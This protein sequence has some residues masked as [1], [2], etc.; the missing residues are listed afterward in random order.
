GLSNNKTTP[1]ALKVKTSKAV[2]DLYEDMEVMS[3]VE[4]EARYEIELEAYTKKIQIESR[5][6][7]DIS[8]NHVVP[9]AIIYQ[10]TLLENTKNLKEIF[11]ENF[12][13]IAKEQI[14]LIMVIS[15]HIT[16]I[17]A[18]VNKMTQERKNANRH[19]GLKS[20]ELYCN[21]VKPFFEEIRYHCDKLETMVDDNL[22]PLTK[23]RELLFTR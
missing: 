8:R 14:E 6:L 22:W 20:A 1:A 18:L 3:K 10:N 12:K 11:G 9:T 23:Y 4:I 2:I 17:N 16:E 13:N 15:N 19:S 7:A 21:Q 5:V